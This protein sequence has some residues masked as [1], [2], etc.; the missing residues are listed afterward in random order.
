MDAQ[1]HAV[2]VYELWSGRIYPERSYKC[3]FH[4][5]IV[6]KVCTSLVTN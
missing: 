4:N 3:L 2:S 6:M 1:L 5:Y